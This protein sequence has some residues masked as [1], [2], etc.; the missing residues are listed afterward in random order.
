M[1]TRVIRGGKERHD[2]ALVLNRFMGFMKCAV[3]NILKN[4]ACS[5]QAQRTH[6]TRRDCGLPEPVRPGR[7]K[8]KTKMSSSDGGS[9]F[10]SAAGAAAGTRACTSL[11]IAG[12]DSLIELSVEFLSVS[13]VQLWH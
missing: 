13:V 1:R 12:I 6:E 11:C 8:P 3:T 10:D 2:F 5:E 9:R 4:Q 7:A